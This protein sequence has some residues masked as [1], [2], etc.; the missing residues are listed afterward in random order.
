MHG[1]HDTDDSKNRG[2]RH[3]PE[4]Q[5]GSMESIPHGGEPLRNW[6]ASHC[7]QVL[8]FPDHVVTNGRTRASDRIYE[9]TRMVDEVVLH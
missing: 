4:A 8:N 3:W 9:M 6:S 1:I 7:L 5:V 2:A